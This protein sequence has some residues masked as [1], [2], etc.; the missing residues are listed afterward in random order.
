M[1]SFL[2]RIMPPQSMRCRVIRALYTAMLVWTIGWPAAVQAQ[3]APAVHDGH[4]PQVVHAANGTP[5]VNIVAPN[6][7]GVSHNTYDQL[8]V[9]SRGLIFNNSAQISKTQLAG[10]IYGNA[11]LSNSGSARIILNEVT[12]TKASQLD[13]Y[14]EVAGSPAEL[15]IANPNGISCNGCGFINTPRGVLTTGTPVFGGDGSLAAFRVVRGGIHIGGSGL[16]ASG[17]DRVDL[18]ARTVDLNAKLWAQRLNVVVGANRIAY[19]DLSAQRI[20]GEGDAP[21]VG[22]DVAALGG[23][24]ANVIHLVGT[25]AGVG[26]NNE[27]EIAAQN[28]DFTLTNTGSVVLNGSVSAT[29]ALHID[30]PQEVDIA[31]SAAAQA[32]RISA[33]ALNVTGLLYGEQSLHL[34]VSGAVHNGGM[35]QSQ[36]GDL[37]LHADGV[38]TQDANAVAYAGG[39]ITLD[40]AGLDNQGDME[41]GHAVDASVSGSVTN[42]GTFQADGGALNLQAAELDN[43]GTI[44]ANT[45]AALHTL[46]DFSNTGIVFSGNSMQLDAGGSLFTSHVIQA[47]TSLALHGGSLDNR[48]KLYALDGDM[49]VS[50]DGGISN[51]ANAEVYAAGALRLNGAMLDNAGRVQATRSA[52]VDVAQTLDNT[53]D[54]QAGTSL[55]IHAGTVNNAGAVQ[56]ANDLSVLANDA[57]GN[58]AGGQLRADADMHLQSDGTLTNAGTVYA[59][60]T[61]DAGATDALDNSGVMAAKGDVALTADH[62]A[63]GGTLAAGL[64]EDGSLADSGDLSVDVTHGWNASGKNLA[65]AH[66]SMSGAT[67]DL[68]GSSTL[69]GSALALVTN[70]GDIVTRGARVQ[71]GSLATMQAAGDFINGGTNSADGGTLRA[72]T[73]YLDVAGLDNRNGQILQTGTDDAVL[74]ATG[75][76]LNAYGTLAVNAAAFDLQA[77]ALENGHG[78]IQHAGHGALTLTTAGN[79]HNGSGQIAGNGSLVLQAGGQLGNAA[80]SLSFADAVQ[81]H[82]DQFDNTGGSLM[83]SSLS[84][85]V[86]NQL[87]NDGGVLQSSNALAVQAGSLSNTGGQIKGVGSALLRVTTNGALDNGANG[88]IGSNGG[89]QV[90]ADTLSN[91]GQIYAGSALSTVTQSTLDNSH[92]ALQAMQSMQID[93]G[94]TLKNEQGRIEAGSGDDAATLTVTASALDNQGGR[95]A[96]SGTGATELRLQHA[97]DNRGGTLGG[98]GDVDVQ[99]SQFDNR[100]S[101][102][103]VS[104]Q[105]LGLD[106]SGFDNAGG[107]VYAAGDI[108]W[109]HAG[110]SLSNASG[111]FGAAHDLRLNLGG[112]GNAGGDLDAGRDVSLQFSGLSGSGRIVAGRDLSL[113]LPGSYTNRSGSTLKANRDLSLDFGGDFTNAAGANL[114]AVSALTVHANNIHNQA[115]AKI[116][117]ADTTLVATQTLSNAG[118]IEGDDITLHAAQLNNTGTIIGGRIT[119]YVHGLTN[120]A[121][122]GTTTGNAA[123]QSA[124]IAATDSV[125]LYVRDTLLNRDATIF[126][127]GDMVLAADSAMHATGAITNRSGDIEADGTVRL[128]TNKFTNERRVFETETYTLSGTEQAQNTRNQTLVRYR[129]DDPDTTHQ[130]PIVDPMQVVSAAEVA[131]ADAYC[132]GRN[133]DHYRCIG[134]PY[135]VGSATTF[136]GLLDDT[137]VSVERLLRTSAEGR[138]L[139]GNDI[140]IDGSVLNDKSTIAAGRNLT[141]NGQSGTN[142]SSVKNIAWE[143]TARVQRSAQWQVRFE[144]EL[145]NTQVCAPINGKHRCWV[146]SSWE[147]YDPMGAAPNVS[148]P[149][150]ISLA[151]GQVPS[152]VHINPGDDAPASIT[153]GQNLSITAHNIDNTA[154]G[155]D[156]KPVHGAVSLGANAGGSH[157]GGASGTAVGSVGAGSAGAGSVTLPS[158]GTGAAPQVVTGPGATIQLPQSG[159]YN[160]N[161]DP[162]SRYLVET[163][164]RFADYSKFISSDYLLDHLGLDPSNVDKRLGDGFYEQRQ[165]LDQITELTGHRYLSGDTDALAQYRDLMDN[166]IQQAS[167]FDLTV[168]VALTAE[169]MAD[170]T[171]DMVWLVSEDVDGQQVLV[172]VVYLSA[173]HA[174]ALAQQGAQIAGKNV[175]LDASGQL[176]NGGSIQAGQDA[177]LTANNLLNSGSIGAGGNLSIDAAQDILNGGSIGAGGNVSVVAGNDIRS[178]LD[179]AV[180]LGN[181][182]LSPVGALPDLSAPSALPGGIHAGGNLSVGAGHDLNLDAAPI[183]AGAGLRLSSGHDM[184]ITASS[185]NAGGDAQLLVGGDIHLNAVASTTGQ[186]G[187]H[188][189]HTD[190]TRNV[191]TQISAGGNLTAIAGHDLDSQG[192]QLQSGNVLAL[193]AGHDINLQTVTD[194]DH[195][196]THHAEGRTAVSEDHR[197]ETLRGTSLQ[198]A[199]GVVVQAGHDA[200]LTATDAY[201]AH[202]NVSVAAG[203]DVHLNAGNEQHDASRDTQRSHSGILSSSST[204][205]HDATQDS[206]AVGTTLS[207]VNVSVTA[208]HDLTTQGAQI[209]ADQAVVLGAGHDVDLGAATDTHDEQHQRTTKKRGGGMGILTG[210]S[211]GDLFTRHSTSQT[212][213]S[214]DRTAY[215]TAISGDSVSIAAGHDLT[216]EGAQVGATHDVVMAAGHDLTIGTATSTHS[217]SHSFKNRT[218][219]AQRSGLHGMFG[220]SKGTQTAS[221]TDVTPTGSLI[222]SSD[223][224]VTLTAGH[225]VH[226]TGSDVLSQ[227][228]TAIVGQNVTIDAAMGSVDTHQSQSQ[229]TGGIMAGLTGGVVSQAESAYASGQAISR[230]KNKRLKALYAVQGAYAAHDA[231]TGSKFGVQGYQGQVVPGNASYDKNG[232]VTGANADGK[233]GAANGSGVSL[234][235]GIGAST[236]NSHGDTHDD[237]AYGSHI[238]SQGDVTI[239]ATNGDLNIIGSQVHGQNVGLSASHDLNLLSQ[240]EQRT[241]HQSQANAGGEVGVSIGQTTGIYATVSGGKGRTHGNGT[242]HLDTQVS[243]DDT[244][245]LIAGHD[246]TIKGAQATGNKVLADIGHDLNIVSEQDTNDY[247][248]NNWQGSVTVVYG[249]SGGGAGVSGSASAGQTDSKYKSVTQTSGIAAGGGG[250]NIYVGN[251]TDLTGGVIASTADPSKN[252]FSTGS[253]SY[254]DLQNEASYSAWSASVGGG[255]GTGQVGNGMSGFAPSG[256]IPQGKSSSS[257]THAGIAQG[258]IDIRNNPGQNLSGLDRNPDID[259]QGLKT[260]FDAQKVAENQEAGQVAGYVGMRTVG[261]IAEHEYNKAVNDKYNAAEGS[262]EEADAEARMKAWGDGGEYKT[263][264]HG[265][266]GAGTAALGGGNALQGAVGATASE[267]ASA[268]MQQYLHDHGIDPNS[269]KGRSLMNL[270]SLGVGA[271]AGGGSGA[272]TALNGEQYN[273]Q[274]H[275]AELSL[276]VGELAKE[277]ASDYNAAH[278]DDSISERDAEKLLMEQALRQVDNQW[279]TEL[280]PDDGEARAWLATHAANYALPNGEQVFT[281]TQAEKNNWNLYSELYRGEYTEHHAAE[282]GLG[283]NYG[284]RTDLSGSEFG[285]QEYLQVADDM[286]DRATLDALYRKVGRGESLTESEIHE[287]SWLQMLKPVLELSTPPAAI[288]ISIADGKYKQAVGQSLLLLAPAAAEGGGLLSAGKAAGSVYET[289]LWQSLGSNDS[290]T[291]ENLQALYG[292]ANVTQGGGNVLQMIERVTGNIAE[293]QSAH[294]SSN[295]DIFVAKSDQVQW[296]YQADSWSM[297]TLPK[298][299]LVYGGLPGQSAYYTDLQALTDAN[300]NSANLFQSLQVSP[301]PVFGYRPQMGMYEVLDDIH[302]PT[303]VVKENPALGPGGANQFFIR[304]Y[305]KNL[306]L[307]KTINLGH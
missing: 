229:H 231:Y 270:A 58:R 239:A 29:G 125:A 302:V 12:S 305:Q 193:G 80:G 78:L 35:L 206:V 114:E 300:S 3:V 184:N 113:H 111:S 56:A 208:G 197:D 85:A 159:L 24:Y 210:T 253:L 157:V 303:G 79:L 148:G 164:P 169:Q 143:P 117:S 47:G 14:M 153:A 252:L 13:G 50:V 263:I 141:I 16:D 68:S 292:S 83:G 261:A 19:G 135:G 233:Q 163:D 250:Y 1:Q 249:F 260:I 116:N 60:G 278:P 92:G 9:D 299:S 55:A 4:K 102:R 306:K 203:H 267:A 32:A 182:D 202:G 123:Y 236:Y 275:P 138:L 180:A 266:I 177:S 269:V 245:S 10:Y 240:A 44:G 199:N 307:I 264:L 152:W 230:T 36:D 57:L 218:T 297:T 235:I 97:L 26:V 124:L 105:H 286:R 34:D 185:I 99:A 200:N 128:A 154:V 285:E 170:L 198:G 73:L 129:Y 223:G 98:Q 5:V 186:E 211:K 207:G 156:G 20:D 196:L 115:G 43:A 271:A 167:S 222:G 194:V 195:S 150:T 294:A 48:G 31:G 284:L 242:T 254:S 244:L 248:S 192:A 268:Q 122:L 106:L 247:A 191:V 176:T 288:G 188:Y 42:A 77:G 118:R 61:L 120:G 137:V 168:G 293:S 95:L 174:Q 146:P 7:K 69:A 139:A 64:Q 279:A 227:T 132:G 165:V 217:E 149:V 258:T 11:K 63:N 65:G 213:T 280:G 151:A 187:P 189:D 272:V 84:A 23:M 162:N 93:A 179:A 255:Y 257:V 225:D 28:G 175:V 2:N 86:A 290:L 147:T 209:G 33:G 219:G 121:D 90:Q 74:H 8:D 190:T 126:T 130:L 158:A 298:G 40:L 283:A 54:V 6:A 221:E 166:G 71:A 110:A 131:A 108:D 67:L 273:R 171:E 72:G 52:Q 234:R 274:L 82:A 136:Q 251:H 38:L 214:E 161:K 18:L 75:T 45:D 17:I 238:K 232:K 100:Q 70:A 256:S 277:Y 241:Q 88:F 21:G 94:G 173:A 181:V 127:T 27:G 205:T 220:V 144:G 296:G 15:I 25:E 183:T 66:L 59:G 62:G 142:Q 216:T 37:V 172:P 103:L 265:M 39:A 101:G 140:H 262:A 109:N 145:H 301:H 96:N 178:G 104:S 46:G 107:T 201:S 237:V 215:G 281:A 119:A 89:V 228:G 304:W 81:V 112:V 87:K 291:L 224:A 282:L 160:I 287:V 53:G 41:A 204:T 133:N 243:A 289:P 276:I 212:D 22:I 76:F 91:A 155:A 30:T 49:D 51:A 295:F 259:A 134:Y 226:I 246:A